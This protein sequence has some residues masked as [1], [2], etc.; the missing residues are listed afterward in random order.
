MS[1]GDLLARLDAIIEMEADGIPDVVK[2]FFI[3]FTLWIPSLK[4]RAECCVAIIIFFK[5]LLKSGN[6]ACLN[7]PYV[8]FDENI[9][10]VSTILFAC[11]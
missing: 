7:F 3:G 11:P 10:S 2:D 8:F 5:L 6:C 9:I 4:F 1:L